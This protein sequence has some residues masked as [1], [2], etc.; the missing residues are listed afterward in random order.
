MKMRTSRYVENL[1]NLLNATYNVKLKQ[2]YTFYRLCSR[3]TDRTMTTKLCPI[4]NN[5]HFLHNRTGTFIF[6]LE[7]ERE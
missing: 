5:V 2:K 1:R 7:K 3:V 6:K 4:C